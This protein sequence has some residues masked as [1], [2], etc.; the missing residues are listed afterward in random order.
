MLTAGD[1]MTKN[2]VSVKK[3]T[4]IYD[5]LEIMRKNDITGIPVIE[6]D[7]TLVGIITEKDVLKLFYANDKDQ[8]KTVDSFMTQPAVSFAVDES[9]E[10][11][12]NFLMAKYFRRVPVVSPKGKLVGIISRPDIINYIL[13]QKRM[14]AMKRSETNLTS[15]AK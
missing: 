12:C 4:P 3:D 1:Y 10:S 2:V 7:M 14:R 8:N 9:L 11:V 6:D 15:S 5:A 13:L